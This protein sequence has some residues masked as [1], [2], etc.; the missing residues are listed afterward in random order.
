MVTLT[1]IDYVCSAKKTPTNVGMNKSQ[2]FSVSHSMHRMKW[3]LS[4]RS[5]FDTEQWI[6]SVICLFIEYCIEIGANSFAWPRCEI[7]SNLL[8]LDTISA[9]IALIIEIVSNQ[10]IYK[11]NLN[12]IGWSECLFLRWA[13]SLF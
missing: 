9:V 8:W 11:Y 1:I 4:F 13:Q 2:Q 10:K 3:R 7:V 12:G 6:C 5:N